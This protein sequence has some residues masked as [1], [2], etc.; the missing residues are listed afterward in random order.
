LLKFIENI[1]DKTIKYTFEI[2]NFFLFFSH[3]V[4]Y[5]FTPQS[6]NRF[7]KR[8]FIKQMYESSIK[9]LPI[10]FFL[11][12]IFGSIFIVIT[13][14][15]AA[16][17]GLQD[18]IGTLIVSFVLNEFAP[19]FTTLFITFRYKYFISSKRALKKDIHDLFIHIYV[20]KLLNAFISIPAMALFFASVMLVSGYVVSA[21]Y[22][23]IDLGTYE[24]YIIDALTLQT[25]SV[26]FLKSVIFAFITTLIPV[27]Y[28]YRKD[29][30]KDIA[31]SIIDIFVT[32]L[33][34]LFIIEI[35]FLIVLY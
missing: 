6:Y 14:L 22:L 27:Y 19:I 21:I 20:P 31:K 17:F 18:K 29:Y 35:L 9:I 33:L 10:F 23:N 28:T 15:F 4:V 12:L 25:L 34:S 8:F 7:S 16:K 24:A 30:T 5:I 1:G 13:I 32:I 26:L 11:A 3:S 2:I